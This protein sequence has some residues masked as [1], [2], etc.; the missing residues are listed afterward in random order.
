MDGVL[1]ALV[2]ALQRLDHNARAPLSVALTMQVQAPDKRYQ[3]VVGVSAHPE[4]L[5][6][7]SPPL[8]LAVRPGPGGGHTIEWGAFDPLVPSPGATPTGLGAITGGVLISGVIPGWHVAAA[9]RP[10]WAAVTDLTFTSDTLGALA[11]LLATGPAGSARIAIADLEVF[12]EG[13]RLRARRVLAIPEPHL[14]RVETGAVLPACY[15][16]TLP[17]RTATLRWS[18]LGTAD[19]RVPGAVRALLSGATTA[20]RRQSWLSSQDRRR[21]AAAVARNDAALDPGG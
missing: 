4:R 10:A 11:P 19:A 2:T 9:G 21:T 17:A 6:L 1:P 5:A 12:D 7:L 3:V 18:A 15:V 13:R 14:E 20:R 8:L 16:P